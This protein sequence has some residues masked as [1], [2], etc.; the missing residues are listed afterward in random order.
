MIYLFSSSKIENRY[1]PNAGSQTKNCS[2]LC[3]EV[4]AT[5]QWRGIFP[6]IASYLEERNS[7]GSFTVMAPAAQA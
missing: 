6:S 1:L 4:V 3:E 2:P 7:T 5:G